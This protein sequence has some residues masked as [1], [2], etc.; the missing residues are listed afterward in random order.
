MSIYKNN[1]S[2]LVYDSIQESLD[3][4]NICI[5]SSKTNNGGCYG[6]PALILL[7]CVI[8]SMGGFY[9]NN[10]F[11]WLDSN[12]KGISQG[13]HFSCFYDAFKSIIGCVIDKTDFCKGKFSVVAAYRNKSVHNGGLYG[14]C[15]ITT[16]GDN[17]YKKVDGKIILNIQILYNTISKCFE[18]FKEEHPLK[19]ES[20]ETN[21]SCT[22]NTSI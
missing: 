9:Q 4:A 13:H 22:G 16:E 6:M 1:V 2:A 15:I 20:L 14:N 19:C 7:C 18:K 12:F 3:A 21:T 17:L 11:K 8:D 10:M 5:K